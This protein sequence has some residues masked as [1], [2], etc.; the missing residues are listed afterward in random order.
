LKLDTWKWPRFMR[1]TLFLSDP[2]TARAP[3]RSREGPFLAQRR[4]DAKV[5]G[6]FFHPCHPCYPWL[7]LFLFPSK[8]S[9]RM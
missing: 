3:S 7:H 2:L 6:G 9:S 5:G 8:L 1:S 4:E